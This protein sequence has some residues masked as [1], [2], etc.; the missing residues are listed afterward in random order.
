M[1][2]RRV[3]GER[4]ARRDRP[5]SARQADGEVPGRISREKARVRARKP[6]RRAGRQRPAHA[7]PGESQTPGRVSEATPTHSVSGTGSRTTR[8]E[9][10]PQASERAARASIPPA[11]AGRGRRRARAALI[12]SALRPAPLFAL[13]PRHRNDEPDRG[14]TRRERGDLVVDETGREPRFL[15]VEPHVRKV[16]LGDERLL[17]KDDPERAR[18]LEAL[19]EVARRTATASPPPGPPP[20][21]RCAF[22][23]GSFATRSTS[24]PKIS[25]IARTNSGERPVAY[26]VPSCAGSENFSHGAFIAADSRARDRQ[27]LR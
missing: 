17:R 15:D 3:R 9:R 21:P 19:L 6:A 26:A 25:R 4:E 10:S 16:E 1:P 11:R 24:G 23:A 22:P 8:R 5:V 12:V 18:R 20:S 27:D 7:S 13:P 14:Q 2:A